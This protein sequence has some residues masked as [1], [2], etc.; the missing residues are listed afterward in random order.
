MNS[1]M[2][3]RSVLDFLARGGLACGGYSAL[4]RF[5]ILDA[6]AADAED[7]N[8]FKVPTIDFHG[9]KVSRLGFGMMR[10]PTRGRGEIDEELADKLV[11]YAYRHGVNYFDTAWMYVGGRSQDYTG[12]VLSKYDRKSV[13]IVNKMPPEGHGGARNLENAKRI[14]KTQL[15]ATRSDYFDVYLLHSLGGYRQYADFYLR[16]GVLD[17]LK[18]EK[19]EGRI[20][21]LGFSFHGS[22][23]D[24]KRYLD[25]K[26]KWDVIMIQL[27]ADGNG[28]DIYNIVKS[29]G[30]P[31]VT[32]GSLHAGRLT[33][34]NVAARKALEEI[35]PGLTPAGWAL[36]WV[37]SQKNV[38]VAISGMSRYTDVVENCES[39]RDYKPLTDAEMAKYNEIRNKYRGPNLLA[40]TG[41]AYCAPCPSGVDIPGVFGFINT[42]RTD[43]ILGPNGDGK[44]MST[45]D[46]RKFLTMLNSKLPSKTQASHCTSCKVCHP[47]C[48]Q[49]ISISDEFKKINAMIE[50]I[51]KG[52]EPA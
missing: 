16:Q 10:L 40:C 22:Q 46:R 14:Y 36:R 3:R 33:T 32:M 44:G 35:K 18:K 50:A 4:S 52:K 37:T 15:E 51:K 27:S 29:A 39:F 25:E 31:I 38:A 41:C 12:K 6:L 7:K 13:C 23:D 8:P 26:I 11:D 17:F 45:A 47:K 28:H 43:R 34:I 5:A 48:P 1:M 2:T 19:E 21:C 9:R 49:H 30:I 42:C 20:K 24:M